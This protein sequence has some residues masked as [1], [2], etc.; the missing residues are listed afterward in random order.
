MIAA[1]SPADYN[2]EETLSTLRYADRAKQI[3]NKPRINEDPKDALL[4][5]YQQEIQQLKE[6]LQNMQQQGAS[7]AQMN[8]AVV[9]MQSSIKA[10]KAIHSVE[11]NVDTLLKK[12][13]GQG[14]KVKILSEEDEEAE[15]K[16]REE[17]Q[18][19]FQQKLQ[20]LA[21]VEQEKNQLNEA[22]QNIETELQDK[23]E[24]LR[25]EQQEKEKLEALLN[26]MNQAVVT[27]SEQLE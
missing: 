17:E 27:G 16:K 18:A 1:L 14:K 6:M 4:R 3:K 20:D 15:R 19:V 24:R 26:E 22:K 21:Q 8:E 5:E 11:D 23:E 12:L 10:Q 25:L 7:S 9:A 13:E 2:Y